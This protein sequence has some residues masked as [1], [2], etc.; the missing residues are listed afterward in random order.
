MAKNYTT[1]FKEKTG[2][3]TGEEPVY[4]VEITHPQ[5]VTPIRIVNDTQDLVHNGNTFFAVAFRIRFP[6][7]IS[8]SVP[9]VP[10]SIDNVGREMTQFLEQSAGGK[11]SQFRIMQVM[12]DTPNIVEQ[13]YTL[14]LAGVRQNMLEISASLSYENFLDIPALAATFTPETA[15]GLF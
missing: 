5:L 1:N 3:T 2:G 4:L 14:T 13:E 10:I 11:G 9:Q 6:D 12:R 15:P 8:R 7:D